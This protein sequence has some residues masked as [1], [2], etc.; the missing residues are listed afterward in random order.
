MSEMDLLKMVT[1]TGGGEGLGFILTSFEVCD[2]V[3]RK[4]SRTVMNKQA[5]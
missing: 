2:D 5:G 1:S 3:D 4:G